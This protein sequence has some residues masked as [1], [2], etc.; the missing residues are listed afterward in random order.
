MLLIV[1]KDLSQRRQPLLAV[2]LVLERGAVCAM[3]LL[4]SILEAGYLS[5]SSLGQRVAIV[6]SNLP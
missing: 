6:A 5:A 1:L 4:G 2:L 3:N